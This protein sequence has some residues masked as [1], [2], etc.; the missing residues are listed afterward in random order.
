MSSQEPAAPSEPDPGGGAPE[1]AAPEPETAGPVVGGAEPDAATLERIAEPAVLRRAPR[2]GSFIRAG[3]VLGAVVGAL[4]AALAPAAP[5]T[6]RSAVIGLAAFGSAG[7]GALLGAGLA[8]LAD[9]RSG[10]VR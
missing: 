1:P 10:R 5:D 4:L 3:V 8:V 9:R 7:L 6:P 2:Y